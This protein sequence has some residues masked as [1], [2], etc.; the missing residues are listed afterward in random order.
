MEHFPEPLT[1]EQLNKIEI[2]KKYVSENFDV[3]QE[4]DYYLSNWLMARYLTARK[5]DLKKA[6][7]MIEGYFNFKKR[8]DIALAE[9][10]HFYG[11]NILF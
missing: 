1:R 2:M 9:N 5:Y 4:P 7:K 6:Q 3:S 10:P 11:I 8:M